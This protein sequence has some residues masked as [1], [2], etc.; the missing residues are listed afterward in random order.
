MF[1]DIVLPDGTPSPGIGLASPEDFESVGDANQINLEELAA[2]QPQ[3]IVGAMWDD[4]QFYGIDAEQLDAVE[5]IAP[6]I[7]IRVDDRPVTEP[8][9][10]VAELAERLGA[11]PDGELSDAEDA[12]DTASEGFAAA[13]EAQPDLLVAA[14]SGSA[15]EMYVAY[16]PKWP[17]LSYYQELGMNLVEP[18][19]HPTSGGFWETLS[20]EEAGKY[21]VDL[22]MADGRGGSLESIK[23]QIPAV[24]LSMPALDADQ[25]V[26]WPAVHA[27]GYGYFATILDDLT[28]AVAESDADVNS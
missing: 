15:T 6:L 25:I 16:P 4:E 1:G 11:D 9:A 20:W 5:Q 13:N 10:R 22:V 28:T 19:D 12:F 3:V 26:V 23:D 7:G 17:D 8:L 14:V 27:Y 24:A 21:P 2:K 18:K